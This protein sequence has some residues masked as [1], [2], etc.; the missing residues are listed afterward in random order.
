MR[1]MR[2][3]LLI[4]GLSVLALGVQPNP[5]SPSAVQQEEHFYLLHPKLGQDW[6]T[7]LTLTNL[8]DQTVNVTLSAYESDGN[9]L[10]PLQALILG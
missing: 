6:Q 9:S 8:D 10:V 3:L 1:T 5:Q 4:L 7:T 2:S